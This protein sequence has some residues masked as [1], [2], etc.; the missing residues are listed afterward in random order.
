MAGRKV[1]LVT[2]LAITFDAYRVV[3]ADLC[4]D[5]GRQQNGYEGSGIAHADEAPE[6]PLGVTCCCVD[7]DSRRPIGAVRLRI[8]ALLQRSRWRKPGVG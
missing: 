1:E 5:Q 4:V 3:G 6:G 8:D 2:A 7:Q